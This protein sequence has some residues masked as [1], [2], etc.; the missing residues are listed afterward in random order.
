MTAWAHLPNAALIDWAV[1]SARKD[2]AAWTAAWDAIWDA[3]QAASWDASR[4]AARGAVWDASRGAVWGA[5]WDA[6]WGTA[7]NAVWSAALGAARA[8]VWEA[9]LSLIAY[10]DCGRLLE[11]P[12]EQ[13]RFLHKADPTYPPYQ[14]LQAALLVRQ[15]EQ[16]AT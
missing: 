13:L 6:I 3:S 7:R 4:T 5:A 2:P 10:D 11:L 12:V 9:I 14:L 16:S 8:A 1:C 15:R